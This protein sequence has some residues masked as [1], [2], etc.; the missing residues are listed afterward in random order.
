MHWS[1]RGNLSMN[2]NDDGNAHIFRETVGRKCLNVK[3][4]GRKEIVR[5]A[6]SS[7][8][9]WTEFSHAS[10]NF[11]AWHVTMEK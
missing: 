10:Y 5:A 11:G 7:I 4:N 1:G 3:S 8:L 2:T 6:Q 9:N